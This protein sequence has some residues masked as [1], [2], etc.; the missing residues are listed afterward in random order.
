MPTFNL[1]EHRSASRTQRPF[2]I[3]V[4]S[5]LCATALGAAPANQMG[6]PIAAVVRDGAKAAL[7]R[8]AVAKIAERAGC[9]T[10]CQA[11]QPAEKAFKAIADLGFKWVDLSCL[12]W[13]QHAS[14]PALLADFDQ[15][16]AR[17]E[18]LL[19]TNGLRTANLTYD[20][21]DGRPFDQFEKEFTVV[22]KL[23]VRLKARLINLMAPSNKAERQDAAAKLKKLQAIAATNGVLLTLETHCNQLTEQSANA[24]WLCQQTPGLGLT[25]DPSHYY[26]GPN[27]GRSFDAVYPLIQGTG[28]RAGG[29][30]WQEI[31][32]PW[33]EGPIDFKAVVCKLEAAGYAGFYVAEYIEGFNKLDALTESKKFLEWAKGL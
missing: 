9:S 26:A 1:L 33:G 23:A 16:A 5:A 22:V 20:S 12:S 31:Q 4:L 3:S 30:S 8:P 13:A 25:L 32:M 21:F 18:A 6:A 27:Q 15:E 17:V 2:L 19:A 24:L 29:M 10:L 7:P 28:F 14:V 11:K